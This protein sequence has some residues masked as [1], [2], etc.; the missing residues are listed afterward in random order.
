MPVQRIAIKANAPPSKASMPPH[1]MRRAATKNTSPQSHSAQQARTNC[2]L[3]DRPYQVTNGPG[4]AVPSGRCLRNF[5]EHLADTGLELDQFYDLATPGDGIAHCICFFRRHL[6]KPNSFH[7]STGASRQ[8]K[9]GEAGA[10]KRHHLLDRSARRLGL[11]DGPLVIVRLDAK[12]AVLK[13]APSGRK[14]GA[15]A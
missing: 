10:R 14:E 4:L 15:P 8:G 3:S 2:C 13:T 5:C 6:S 11:R 12:T 9:I 7:R 1:T